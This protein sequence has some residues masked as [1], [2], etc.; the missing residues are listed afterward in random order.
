MFKYPLGDCVFKENKAC[1][2]I[3]T[4]THSR[5]FTVHLNDSSSIALPL[6]TH[7]IP[8][9]MF[10]IIPVENI[11]IVAH[12]IYKLRQQIL[13]AQRIKTKTKNNPKIIR[14]NFKNNDTWK[15]FWN[16]FRIFFYYSVFFDN[17]LY[18]LI[19]FC[20]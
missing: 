1:V 14:I 3:T 8:K 6:K 10:R 20:F 7:S 18:P 5:R 4:T 2:V 12:V 15:K 16:A 13:E 11:T 9:S 17:V 19:A